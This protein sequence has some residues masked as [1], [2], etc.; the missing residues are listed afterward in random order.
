MG[1]EEWTG[2]AEG[3]K[4]K[5]SRRSRGRRERGRRQ[6]GAGRMTGLLVG[7]LLSHSWGSLGSLGK[8]GRSFRRTSD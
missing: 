6:G 7:G 8:R 3:S 2:A 1:K 4:G 5:A